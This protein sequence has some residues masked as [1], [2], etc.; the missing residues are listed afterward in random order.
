[1]KKALETILIGLG[2]GLIAW[3]AR[4]FYNKNFEIRPRIYFRLEQTTTLSKFASNKIFYE[5]VWRNHFIIKNN[6]SY[7]AFNIQFYIPHKEKLIHNEPV[8]KREFPPN[9][10]L[11]SLA[12][13]QATIET[14]N[15]IK[16][17]EIFII[18]NGVPTDKKIN[19]SIVHFKPEELENFNILVEYENEKG[20]KFYTEFVANKNRLFNRRKRKLKKVE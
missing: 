4:G 19:N 18:E 6:S 10:H 9:F 12:E 17:S 8:F 14:T 7:T 13:K 2:T 16:T 3:V 1:M 15:S 11:E 20:K 5:L